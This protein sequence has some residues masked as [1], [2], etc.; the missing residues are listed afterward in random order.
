MSPLGW[1]GQAGSAAAPVVAAAWALGGWRV[2]FAFGDGS[3]VQSEAWSHPDSAL[4]PVQSGMHEGSCLA[5]VADGASGWLSA[6]DDGRVMQLDGEGG[7]R[8]L[9]RRDGAWI[10]L[11]A[12]GKPGLRAWAEGRQLRCLVEGRSCSTTLPAP[13][14]ALA[15]DPQGHVLAASHHGGVTLWTPADGRSRQLPGAGYPRSLA[16][17]PDSRYLV[18]GLQENG[19]RGWRTADGRD[20][21]MGGYP[22]QPLSLSFAGNGRY[23]ATS[24]AARPV[25]W[26]FDP[27]RHGEPPLECGPPG[28]APVTCVACHPRLPLI[29]AGHHSGVVLLCRLGATDSIPLRLPPQ[30]PPGAIN[31]LVWSGDGRWLAYGSQTGAYGWVGLPEGL[32]R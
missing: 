3:V 15:F 17:S 30:G 20:I 18:V 25:C 32:L 14:T 2:A 13:A 22:G 16:W 1:T 7:C 23:L 11:L 10:G 29:A 6:G 28:R 8:E 21:E 31:A 27:P 12:A 24:G 4:K 19:L 9:Y 5:L 26:R